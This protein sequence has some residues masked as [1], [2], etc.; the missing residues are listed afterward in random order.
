MP[1]IV[2][3]SWIKK[4]DWAIFRSTRRTAPLSSYRQR[5]AYDGRRLTLERVTEPVILARG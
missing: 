3:I 5:R 4:G 2:S 1:R